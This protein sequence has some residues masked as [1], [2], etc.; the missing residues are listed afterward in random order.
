MT[1]TNLH[2][3]GHPT[4][5]CLAQSGLC[6]ASQILEHMTMPIELLIDVVLEHQ[7]SK[8]NLVS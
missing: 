3:D 6:T 7:D 4:G 5:T 2:G 1:H 8:L